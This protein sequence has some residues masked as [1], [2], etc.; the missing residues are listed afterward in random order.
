MSLC[1]INI[2]RTEILRRAADGRCNLY[3]S[4]GHYNYGGAEPRRIFCPPLSGN[5]GRG[6]TPP[7]RHVKVVTFF[8]HNADIYLYSISQHMH[9]NNALYLHT[10][11]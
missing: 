8:T 11:I 3:Y 7:E 2:V 1:S 9:A 10:N 5:Q 6:H 4:A